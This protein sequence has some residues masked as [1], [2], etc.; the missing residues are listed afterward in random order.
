MTEPDVS[1]GGLS[2]LGD[3]SALQR[4]HDWVL[5]RGNRVTLSALVLAILFSVVYLFVAVGLV[6]F[7]QFQPVYYVF[8]G[9]ISGN[10]T[11][12]TVVVSINQ[13]LL[14]RTLRTPGE[15]ESQIENTEGFKHRVENAAGRV[16]PVRPTAFLDLLM[17]NT[18][19]EAQRLGGLTIGPGNDDAWEEIDDL[20]ASVTRHVDSVVELIENTDDSPFRALSATLTTNY[21][22]QIYRA[23]AIREQRDL[24]DETDAAL[25]RLVDR[26]E[27][28]D[29]ARQYFKTVY[30]QD[31]LSS[32]S[33][34]LLYV[35][36]PAEALCILVLLSLTTTPSAIPPLA[37]DVVLPGIAVVGLAPL[38]VLFSYITR[39]A[40]VTQRTSAMI[41]FTTPGQEE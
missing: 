14:S 10:L 22:E 26:L 18:R 33:R 15:L 32:L 19:R 35:G 24:T 9:L 17:E 12:V 23:R 2:Q 8:G 41:P 21:A 1:D 25:D 7:D 16:A 30:L 29:V 3:R 13:L 37:R 40:T 6:Q 36:V 31:E 20:V 5:L 39:T 27:D 34:M 28:V 11:L 38:A 4:A